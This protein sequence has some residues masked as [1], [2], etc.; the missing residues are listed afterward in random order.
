[1]ADASVPRDVRFQRGVCRNGLTSTSQPCGNVL[2]T[3]LGLRPALLNT[4]MTRWC[5]HVFRIQRSVSRSDHSTTEP[6]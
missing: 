1:M 4:V 3:R 6:V 2:T 5:M